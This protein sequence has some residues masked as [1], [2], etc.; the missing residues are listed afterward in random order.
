ME[1]R[2]FPHWEQGESPPQTQ[3]GNY[4][5][6]KATNMVS[7]PL[8]S[9]PYTLNPTPYTLCTTS[10]LFPTNSTLY[11]QPSTLNPIPSTL[12][13]RPQMR[14]R[15]TVRGEKPPVTPNIYIYIYIY[16]YTYIV[17]WNSYAVFIDNRQLR[18]PL[19]LT[20]R[21]MTLANDVDLGRCTC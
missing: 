18:I 9:E 15:N 12:N 17:Y 13:P 21:Q 4:Y 19:P 11:P 8:H 3:G 16:I 5:W 6:K 14:L 20:K 10:S 1:E 2:M 7:Q